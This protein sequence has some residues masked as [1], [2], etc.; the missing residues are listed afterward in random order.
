MGLELREVLE[1]GEVKVGEERKGQAPG[2]SIP[3]QKVMPGRPE[4]MAHT[5][6][7][8]CRRLIELP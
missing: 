7:P 8:A 6:I 4:V 3:R 5:A 2:A 1:A